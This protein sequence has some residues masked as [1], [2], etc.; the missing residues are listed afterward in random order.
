MTNTTP[1][2]PAGSS[3]GSA[4]SGG[5][6]FGHPRGLST[7]FF[8]EM[9]ERFSFYGMK[10]VLILFMTTAAAGA[11]PGLGI[12]TA[13]AAA[14]YG[15]YTFFVYMLCLPGGWVADRLWGQKRAVFVGG[16]IIMLGHVALAIPSNTSFYIGLALVVTGTGL[17][18]P[19]VSTMVG[20]LYPEGGARRDAGFSVF[21]MG[22]NLGS[23]LGVAAVG[24]LGEKHNFHWGFSLAA[25]GMLLGLIQYR[26]GAKHLEGAGE[27]KTGEAQDVLAARGRKFYAISAAC[28]AAV[29]VFGYL[30]YSGAIGITIGGVA[31][32]L[33]ASVALLAVAYFS[34]LILSGRA[35]LGFIG[36]AAISAIVVGQSIDSA[37]FVDGARETLHSEAI[38]DQLA[39]LRGDQQLL[40]DAGKL[41]VVPADS[42]LEAQMDRA[43]IT[44]SVAETA[45]VARGTLE[46]RLRAY[47]I[48]IGI[49]VL[50]FLFLCAFKFLR[51]PKGEEI[52]N[53]RLFVIF[54]LFL[55]SAVFWMGFEQAGSSMNLFARDYT[56]R[57]FFGSLLPAS[58]LQNVNAF[59]I[60]LLAPVFGFVWT[61][62][63]RKDANP[64]IPVKFALGLL[65]LATGFFVLSWG[66]ANAGTGTGEQVGMSWLIV[67]YFFHTVG[68]LCLS[69]V[70]LSSI[71]KL[72]PRGR[73]GQM[74]GVWFIGAA[75]G[76]L[77]AGLAAA[78]LGNQEPTT[79]FRT[80]SMI[81]GAA[82]I[83]ALLTS[84]MVKRLTG[85]I[86]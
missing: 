85:D 56:D 1:S 58:W 77:F 81:V 47:Q 57:N 33:G 23:F 69:P 37:P 71:T 3:A 45:I 75:L 52:D 30:M 55:L 2:S 43:A 24:W 63:A 48:G 15:L 35:T 76:N 29:M 27:I 8:T 61:W 84:P 44:A 21:Y 16:V 74:M 73:T 38:A 53:K 59:L 22:I 39:V 18:K 19:N 62:L 83:I 41:D 79:L 51:L 17:L 70:G 34:Q 13:E 42:V 50:L 26:L 4:A 28:V 68:E 72:A 46:H 14:I 49:T 12:S 36:V 82:G 11:N 40:K 66:S 65:G 64:S 67:T 78:S 32:V 60:I 54:W 25:I 7:L 80:V 9:W 31:A 10:A 20:D 5:E 86:E 6:W